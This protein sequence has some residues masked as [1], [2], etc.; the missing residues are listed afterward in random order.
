MTPSLPSAWAVSFS[1]TTSSTSPVSPTWIAMAPPLLPDRGRPVNRRRDSPGRPED[2]LQ[3]E[4]DHDDAGAEARDAPDGGADDGRRAQDQP[5]GQVV[6]DALG[7]STH[8]GPP[9]GGRFPARRARRLDQ[10]RVPR[11]GGGL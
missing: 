7:Y 11:H 8:A 6:H 3:A 4:D 1:V 2:E 10:H 5:A 9:G